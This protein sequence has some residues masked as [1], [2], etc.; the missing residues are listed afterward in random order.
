MESPHFIAANWVISG[1]EH[2]WGMHGGTVLVLLC[3]YP[4]VLPTLPLISTFTL[5]HG[6]EVGHKGAA[7]FK[8]SSNSF[9][10]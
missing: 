8:C 9:V 4:A 7:H 1:P 6:V 3:P 2:E 10:T 5:Q